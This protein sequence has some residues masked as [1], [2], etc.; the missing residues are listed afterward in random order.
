MT[1]MGR[2]ILKTLDIS[3]N[4]LFHTESYEQDVL[5]SYNILSRNFNQ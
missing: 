4:L 2:Q 1:V 3:L 5:F